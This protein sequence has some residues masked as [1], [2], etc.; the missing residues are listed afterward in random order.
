MGLAFV[1][2]YL[3]GAV[4]VGL[5]VPLIVA[6]V[7]VRRHGTGNVGAANVRESAGTF[8]GLVVALGVFLQGLLPPLILRLLSAPEVAVAAAAVGAVVGYGWPV[9]LGFRGGRALGTGTGAAAAISPGGFVV[10]LVSYALGAL[11]HQTS[12]GTLLGF[13]AYAGYVFYSADSAAYE[14]AALLLLIVIVARK[15]R[16]FGPRSGVRPIYPD[17]VEPVALPAAPRAS[18]FR[19]R[20]PREL[21]QL[22]S[23]A[24]CQLPVF[25]DSRSLACRQ[26]LHPTVRRSPAGA[27]RKSRGFE[28]RL[29]DLKVSVNEGCRPSSAPYHVG[30]RQRKGGGPMTGSGLLGWVILGGLLVLLISE[31]VLALI[32][33]IRQAVEG[34]IVEAARRVGVGATRKPSKSG[35][36]QIDDDQE[37][38]PGP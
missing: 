27:R 6:G 4:P 18:P 7:D 12:L 5:L 33:Y 31:A 36:V 8:V 17:L 15:V 38:Q 32:P 22:V 34:G 30:R 13:V 28:I 14:A 35:P 25:A 9:F 24:A 10:L 19:R 3:V 2:G 21:T 37:S 29:R 16:G 26:A 23:I 20:E 11:L 1:V